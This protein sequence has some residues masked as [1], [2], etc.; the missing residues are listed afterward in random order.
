[1]LYVDY[2]KIIRAEEASRPDSSLT[3][4]R[5][6]GVCVVDGLY[7]L[8]VM[9]ASSSIPRGAAIDAQDEQQQALGMLLTCKDEE[10]ALGKF[11][12][13]HLAAYLFEITPDQYSQPG[14]FSSDYFLV[15]RE[16]LKEY[17]DKFM[18]S[19]AIWG[20]FW[21]KEQNAASTA[22]VP[23]TPQPIVARAGI[24]M[25]TTLHQAAARRSAMLP[26]AFERYLKLYHLLELSFDHDTVERI[27]SLGD[28]LHGI[29]QILSQHKRDELDRLKQLII[30][31]C[32]DRGAIASCI[33]EICKDRKWDVTTRDIFFEFGKD[34]NPFVDKQAQFEQM[35]TGPG[36]TKRGAESSGIISVRESKQG[37]FE[38]LTLKTAAYW[39]YRVRCSIAHNRIGEYVMK[40]QDEEFVEQFAER[41]LR[42]VLATVLR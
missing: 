33:E 29:G 37:A 24:K 2:R 16:R 4:G 21:H 6:N 25:P 42:Q 31:K 34:G 30:E 36:F 38:I 5:L 9:C 13:A 11:G 22:V 15:K 28:D 17:R 19:S 39:I 7:P 10:Y 1:M 35:I 32:A 12:A 14:S 27:R 8:P 26:Y 23:L 41:L 18:A 40:P 3:I 20:G